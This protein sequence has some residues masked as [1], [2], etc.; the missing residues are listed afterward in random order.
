MARRSDPASSCNGEKG[1]HDTPQIVALLVETMRAWLLAVAM[2]AIGLSG[3]ASAP[4]DGEPVIETPGF[5]PGEL[6]DA[7]AAWLAGNQSAN[8]E[9]IGQW[10]QSAAEIDAWEDHVAVWSG[11]NVVILHRQDDNGTV[12][13]T[14]VSSIGGTGSK[15]VKWSDDGDWIFI[16]NDEQASNTPLGNVADRNGGF[17]VFN[18]ADK[19]VPEQTHFLPVGPTRGPHMVFYHQA[20]DGTEMVLGA[21][22]DI[23]VNTFDRSTGRLTETA[24]YMPAP[25]EV[26]RHP[27]RLDAYYQVY[28]HDMF[29]MTD[30]VT[31][32]E[33]MYVANWDAGLRIVDITDPANIVELGGWNDW[34]EGHSG[35]LHTVST[36]WSG[37]RR[38]TVGA[39]E[40]GFAVVGGKPYALDQ[41]VSAMYIW[42]TTDPANVELISW[43]ENPEGLS[44]GR[45]ETGD[46]RSTHNLQLENGIVTMAHYGLGVVMLDISTPELQKEPKLL[47][48]TNPGSAWDAIIMDGAVLASGGFGVTAYSFPLFELGAPEIDSRA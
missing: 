18:V 46:L 21:N 12:A 43:W 32:Q 13:F 27:D 26:D 35:N 19:A 41:E 4:V 31:G 17:Y 29:A 48:F 45:S 20:A 44:A 6:D 33:L 37:D 3:C 34:P 16:G 22:G 42:D 14:E 30:N 7:L 11:S 28:A 36:E 8:L 15:D 47:G 10:Q 2:I 5:V 40:V 25:T 38:I 23:S 24:R 39:V 1:V 9:L